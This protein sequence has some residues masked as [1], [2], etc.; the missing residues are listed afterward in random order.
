MPELK[1][2]LELK[3]RLEPERGVKLVDQ[4][5]WKGRAYRL[6]VTLTMA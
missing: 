2:K 1:L 3:L 6:L 4:V 5:L